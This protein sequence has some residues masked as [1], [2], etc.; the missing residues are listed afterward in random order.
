MR[1]KIIREKDPDAFEKTINDFNTTH[2]VKA[3]QTHIITKNFIDGSSLI[4]FYAV[5]YYES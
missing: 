4:I 2:K 1:V 3:T 5:L